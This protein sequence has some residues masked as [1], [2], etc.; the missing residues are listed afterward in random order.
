PA[1]SR[2]RRRSSA[3]RTR[4]AAFAEGERTPSTTPAHPCDDLCQYPYLSCDL[5][6]ICAT[7]TATAVRTS[8]SNSTFYVQ[9]PGAL[10]RSRPGTFTVPSPFRYRFSAGQRPV[11]TRREAAAAHGRPL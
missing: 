3:A 10:S 5:V 8:R 2:P 6:V 1:R 7:R 9:V 4:H 11:V